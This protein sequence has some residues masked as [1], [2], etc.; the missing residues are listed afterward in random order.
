MSNN[1]VDV[2]MKIHANVAQPSSTLPIAACLD[3]P[4]GDHTC[5]C[6]CHDPLDSG[7][8]VHIRPCCEICE[9]CGVRIRT[10]AV[11]QHF[12]SCQVGG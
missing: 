9:K 12:E 4:N 3:H 2:L 1:Y 10:E 7:F 8:T 6:D 5:N 11:K